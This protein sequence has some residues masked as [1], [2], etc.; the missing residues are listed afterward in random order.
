MVLTA[1]GADEVLQQL[2]PMADTRCPMFADGDTGAQHDV[3][4]HYC[5]VVVVV[6]VG[7]SKTSRGCPSRR[8]S[9]PLLLV[10]VV[11]DVRDA[12]AA[13]A[14]CVAGG[15]AMKLL[16]RLQTT[17]QKWCACCAAGAVVVVGTETFEGMVAARPAAVGAGVEA[18]ESC[19]WEHLN[20]S[21]VAAAAA[22]A[23][24]ES[25]AGK[26]SAQE[27]AGAEPAAAAGDQAPAADGDVVA[28]VVS[29]RWLHGQDDAIVVAAHVVVVVRVVA[30]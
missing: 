2:V 19:T 25:V 15:A 13:A 18:S 20:L 11:V 8:P 28:V 4:V 27:H 5:G 1:A 7:G 3:V 29:T 12:A 16:G 21:M 10:E 17:R 24:V 6:G 22:A 9:K 30:G 23:D 26:R 14:G